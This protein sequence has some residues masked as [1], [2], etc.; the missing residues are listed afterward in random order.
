MENG[1]FGKIQKKQKQKMGMYF[2]QLLQ[3]LFIY[4]LS[5]YTIKRINCVIGFST[6]KTEKSKSINLRAHIM[7]ALNEIARR[8]SGHVEIEQ[9]FTFPLVI[10]NH[11][12]PKVVIPKCFPLWI[13]HM[14]LYINIFTISLFWRHPE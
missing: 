13:Q 6:K 4:K 7:V 1:F 14:S 2:S 10:L 5:Q 9:V 8:K 11:N 12:L 3:L